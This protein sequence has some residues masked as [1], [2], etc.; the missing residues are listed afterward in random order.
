MPAVLTMETHPAGAIQDPRTTRSVT[1]GVTTYRITEGF[2]LDQYLY[3]SSSPLD[4]GFDIDPYMAGAT[5][6][7]GYPTI[8]H[9]LYLEEMLLTV[10]AFDVDEEQGELDEV[11]FNGHRLGALSGVNG[12]WSVNTFHVP[13]YWVK[14]GPSGSTTVRNNVEVRIDVN[15]QGW[16]VEVA[17]G[18]L[19]INPG[20][21]PVVMVHGLNGAGDGNDDGYNDQWDS[22][23]EFYIDELPALGDRLAAPV[24][25]D[26]GGVET[27]V[28]LLEDA[29]DGLLADTGFNRV[30][31]LAHSFGGLTSRRF[32]FDNLGRVDELVMI[33]TPN[34]GSELATDVC[35]AQRAN[36]LLR[37]IDPARW[38]KIAVAAQLDV[39]HCGDES[40]KIYQLQQW[41][42]RD[43]F[44]ENVRD[45]DSV[46]PDRTTTSYHTI[47]GYGF[48]PANGVLNGEDD[49][50]VELSSVF[51]LRPADEG[52]GDFGRN[53]DHP[54]R[55][56]P[57]SIY[58]L[59]HTQL[60]Q[61]D[62][63]LGDAFCLHYARINAS[64]C[65]LAEDQGMDA[66]AS[67][68][69]GAPTATNVALVGA[70]TADLAPGE[71]ATLNLGLS[72]YE[73]ATVVVLSDRDLST[74]SG[75]LD[76]NPLQQTDML[77]SALTATAVSPTG[78]LQLT[79]TGSDSAAVGILVYAPTDRQ[80]TVE[81]DRTQAS[82]G[83]P[84][85]VVVR[86]DGSTATPVVRFSP[87]DNAAAA[88]TN[89]A[90]EPLG[91]GVWSGTFVPPGGGVWI[92]DA[93]TTAPEVRQ[94]ATAVSVAASTAT[95]TGELSTSTTDENGNG[96]F[97]GLLVDVGIDASEPGSYRIVAD[98]VASD[99]TPVAS[100]TGRGSLPAGTSALRVRAEGRQIFNTAANGPYHLEDVLLTRD[101]DAFTLEDLAAE[102]NSTTAYQYVDFEHDAVTLDASAIVEGTPT[103]ADDDGL[104]DSIV[105]NVPITVDRAGTYDFNGRL[106]LPDGT[107]VTD[108]AG[109]ISLQPGRTVVQLPFAATP[110]GSGNYDTTF[111]LRNLVAYRTDN[112]DAFDFI[113]RSVSTARYRSNQMEGYPVSPPRNATWAQD[114]SLS[115]SQGS[116]N[117][118]T[119]VTLTP[120]TTNSTTITGR[121]DASVNSTEAVANYDI[122]LATNAEF[123]NLVAQR[124]VTADT[125]EVT[126][127]AADG[128]TAGRTYWFRVTARSASATMSA[129]AASGG[130]AV[131]DQPTGP[132]VAHVPVPTAYNGQPIPI[133]VTSTCVT[134]D[135]CEARLFWRRTPNQSDLVAQA[136]APLA[137]G[138][139]AATLEVSGTTSLGGRDA[140]SWTGAIPGIDVTTTGVDYFVEAEDNRAVTRVP[141]GTFIGTDAD[142]DVAPPDT[143][144]WHVHTV[145]P[146][147][148]THAPTPFANTDEDIPVSIQVAC[149]T[150][151]CDATLYYRTTTG[152]ITEETIVADNGE[153]IATPGW[154]TASM[155]LV[156]ST[157][158]GEAGQL[159]TF[160]AE[161]PG[162]FVDTRGVDY[163]FQVSDGTTQAWSPGTTYEG[164]YAPLDGMRTGWYHVHVL[165]PPH[166]VHVAPVTS[167]YR[168]DI[169][170]SATATC[171][172]GR[173]C[174][175]RLYF[176]TTTSDVLDTT[177][178]FESVPMGVLATP[179]LDGSRILTVTGT[180][181]GRVADTRGV[182]YFFSVSDGT[183][184][185]WWPG[186][187]HVDG[188]VPIEGTRVGYQHVRVLD[189]PHIVHAPVGAAPAL[190]D[191]VIEASVTCA[192]ESCDVMLHYQTSLWEEAAY[193]HALPMEQVGASTPTPLGRVATYRATIPAS[194]VTTTQLAYYIEAFDG[195]THGYAP[196]TSYIG[197]YLP[198]DGIAVMSFPV[199]V[200]E[201]PHLVHVPPARGTTGQPLTM[202]ADA[203][204]ST[205]A[206][207]AT[208]HW[209]T[210]SGAWQ[211]ATMQ[212]ASTSL[213]I[214]DLVTYT[215]TVP[216]TDVVPGLQH[217]I[218][219]SDGYVSDRTPTWSLSVV[220]S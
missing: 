41:Y 176:R 161:I 130:L 104:I 126:F 16:A 88:G 42:V 202:R 35:H 94:A 137:Q 219:V 87:A 79:N 174:S 192:T 179:L 154:P 136:T 178:P 4:F 3:R 152:P 98:V 59:N 156:S 27:D 183:T 34:G 96:L 47:G 49:G 44:N 29:V 214:A 10:F 64:T 182:D 189:P 170:V 186:T 206:C 114:V 73:Q 51:W 120:S 177:S 57:W 55:H 56:H 171:P 160:A 8:S 48:G 67:V 26:K 78:L 204:C 164:Y 18:E 75:A 208:L 190:Q 197:A 148:I 215:A 129:S 194:D 175:A 113:E 52:I 132:L 117:A 61:R 153:L 46:L 12:Q 121:W 1:D 77:V 24:L 196:G 36:G 155:D 162:G 218:E 193:P 125:T 33:A 112:L 145:S 115:T 133:A 169:P 23:R 71:T 107:S 105:I 163:F 142:P 210:P 97:D 150:D 122:D 134:G 2:D 13:G 140:L 100:V 118:S 83:Q 141:G 101:D 135:D 66:F 213:D 82:Q 195:Y 203:N 80:L 68:S 211:Q 53:D 188:Y 108:A 158:L 220:T 38:A 81:L 191:L 216:A 151:I 40:S 185:T 90:V 217:W 32:A 85:E 147:V 43:V 123:T 184:T 6:S 45:S 146:P 138:W 187:S 11:W 91:G 9:P 180:I 207:V 92:V 72:D 200:L 76:G 30:N 60:I 84:V 173:Q 143:G 159:L 109:S 70:P 116:G 89:I 166:V 20:P 31:L 157:P 139:H 131:T 17:W 212:A 110:I 199:R 181:P 165:E 127:T 58:N 86:T 62:S 168:A 99:G 201:P 198:T 39:G 103:D 95:L 19:A 5:D 22:A 149:A 63:P 167:A 172:A 14:F 65:P 25:T 93:W 74:L 128:V 102:L 144:Y 21:E 205:G 209:R 15:N 119:S 7:S 106:V 37:Y 124:T 28:G 50:Q 111:E 54:G 69:I